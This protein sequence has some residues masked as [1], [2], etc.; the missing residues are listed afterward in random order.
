[1]DLDGV[2]EIR[3]TSAAAVMSLADAIEHALPAL[4]RSGRTKHPFRG[5]TYYFTYFRVLLHLVQIITSPVSN[6]LKLARQVVLSPA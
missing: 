1:V 5:C 6:P 2:V 3:R 4:G